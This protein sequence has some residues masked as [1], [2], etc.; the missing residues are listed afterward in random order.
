MPSRRR[1]DRPDDAEAAQVR[2]SHREPQDEPG[3]GLRACLEAKGKL[4]AAPEPS[5]ASSPPWTRTRGS[6]R[7]SQRGGA[8]H[9]GCS[10]C[11]SGTNENTP[12]YVVAIM[13]G[14][15][16]KPIKESIKGNQG[17]ACTNRYWSASRRPRCA[18]AYRLGC[19]RPGGKGCLCVPLRGLQG[20][21]LDCFWQPLGR[22]VSRT[23]L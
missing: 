8:R 12:G 7:C 16:K 3:R 18:Q 1:G 6:E 2:V 17:P 20:A 13:C 22:S 23:W 10:S 9:S 21:R 4:H 19:G 14:W 5:R 11:P 15:D